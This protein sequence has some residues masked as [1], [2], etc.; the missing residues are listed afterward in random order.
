M[1]QH[2]FTQVE[3]Q[4]IFALNNPNSLQKNQVGL[5]TETKK[6]ENS[7]P[8]TYK[9]KL[10]VKWFKQKEIDFAKCPLFETF[11]CFGFTCNF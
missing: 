9:A 11:E 8:R 10:L 2:I 7:S 5:Q 4:R 3:I 6:F 1:T